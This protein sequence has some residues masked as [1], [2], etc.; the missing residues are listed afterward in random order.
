MTAGAA[1]TMAPSHGR[2]PAVRA[3]HRAVTTTATARSNVETSKN[4]AAWPSPVKAPPS[5]CEGVDNL[6][7]R[8]ATSMKPPISTGYSTG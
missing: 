7:T 1:A 2:G 3:V 4:V 5:R 8:L 6:A